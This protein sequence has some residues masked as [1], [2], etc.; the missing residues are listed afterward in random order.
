MAVAAVGS[1]DLP[2]SRIRHTKCDVDSKANLSTG[3][4]SNNHHL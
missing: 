3:Q 4:T 1:G 2:Y